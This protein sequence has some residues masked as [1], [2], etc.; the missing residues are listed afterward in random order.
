MN[1][2]LH[3]E[4]VGSGPDMV[5]LHGWGLNS[6]CWQSIVPLL[7]Q[8]FRLHMID[9]PGFGLSHEQFAR[10]GSLEDISA[11]LLEVVPSRA[12]W[13]G[14]SL[15]GLCATHFS[16]NY[17]DRVAALVTVASSP[18]FLA[19]SN[20][21]GIADKVLETFKLQL[22]QDLAKT[23]SR[24]LAI[25]AMGSDSA[26]QDIKL[27]KQYLAFRPQPHAEA[28]SNGLALLSSGDLRTALPQL[29]V[30]VYRLYGRLD[31]LV[32]RAAI[33]QIN[34]LLSDSPHIIFQSSSHAPF[35]S[36]PELFVKEIHKF[37]NK[38]P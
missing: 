36:E 24:F 29:Q 26:K 17:P 14:W 20:W 23:V 15:G 5:L 13:L 4:V 7:S 33:E 19:T 8:S 21:S 28:L 31:S 30:P 12:I 22:Q 32:P 10:S 37:F 27:L 16:L 9:L 6:A 2:N 35:I 38:L 1:N 11:A 34:E 18:K 3:V 25:Q